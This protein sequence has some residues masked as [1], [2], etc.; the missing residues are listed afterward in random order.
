VPVYKCSVF[1]QSS[2]KLD[3]ISNTT[4]VKSFTDHLPFCPVHSELSLALLET[5]YLFIHLPPVQVLVQVVLSR[6]VVALTSSP[7]Y[8]RSRSCLCQVLIPTLPAH[9]HLMHPLTCPQHSK[10]SMLPLMHSRH[11]CCSPCSTWSHRCQ[12][13]SSTSH[14]HGPLCP[15]CGLAGVHMHSR[16]A[17][18]N[19]Q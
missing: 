6:P 9:H 3:L 14:T 2:P 1:Q 5:L 16:C 13:C 17:Y 11:G 19:L 7:I 12:S 10:C 18:Y 15:T 4:V 8:L